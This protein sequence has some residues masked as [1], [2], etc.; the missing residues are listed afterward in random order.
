MR[1][2]A[3]PEAS[4]VTPHQMLKTCTMNMQKCLN[5]DNDDSG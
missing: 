3:L 2:V 4:L 5:T 1:Q